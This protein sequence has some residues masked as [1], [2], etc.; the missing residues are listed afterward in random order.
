MEWARSSLEVLSAFEKIGGS[1]DISGINNLEQLETPC[2]II[3]NHMSMLETLILP[4]IVQPIRNFTFIVKQ[5]LLN[6]PV[7]RHVMR[8]RNPIA[9]IRT[10][11]RQDFK[12]V[13]EEGVERLSRGIS[14]LVFPQTTRTL[15]FDPKDFN[16]IGIKLAKRAKVPVL[17]M[18][19]KTDAWRNGRFL[20]DFGKIDCSKKV[21]FAFGKPMQVE[22]KGNEQH[23]AVIEFIGDK[24]QHWRT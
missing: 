10:N 9:V 14:V 20:K 13:I 6:Y 1:L 16:T 12:I 7:F 24:L 3:G 11:P 19:L 5:S 18:A 23:E 22:G 21:C 4:G 17:P 15:S 2:V 8:S